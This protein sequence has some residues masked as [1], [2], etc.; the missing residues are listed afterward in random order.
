MNERFIEPPD[1]GKKDDTLDIAA[2]KPF[3]DG[4]SSQLVLLMQCATGTNWE[5]KSHELRLE[6]WKKYIHWGCP[7]VPGFAIPHIVAKRKWGN[8]SLDSGLILDRI[9]IYNILVTSSEDKSLHSPLKAWCQ[10][11]INRLDS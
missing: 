8:L 2:W 11:Q 3:H 4:K 1:V 7:P 10:K 6:A 5:E 9:R